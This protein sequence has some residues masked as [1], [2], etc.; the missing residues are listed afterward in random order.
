MKLG[1]CQVENFSSYSS[2]EFDFADLSLSLVYG[3]TGAGKSTLCDIAIW[4]LYGITAKNGSADDVRSWTNTESPTKVVLDVTLANG[5][6]I[7]VVRTRGR[8][9]QNDLYWI[10]ESGGYQ[11][12][13]DMKDTQA[14]LTGVLG[15][16][17]ESYL[18]TAYY[19]DSSPSGAFF[20]ANAKARRELFERI[21]D[22]SFPKR[23][24]EK[25]LE[26]KKS[27]SKE[28][29]ELEKRKS[30]LDGQL[31]SLVDTIARTQI[32]ATDWEKLQTQKIQ[33]LQQL[34]DNFDELKAKKTEAFAASSADWSKDHVKVLNKLTKDIKAL[35]VD[36]K[37]F[38]KLEDELIELELETPGTCLECQQPLDANRAKK[39]ELRQLLST[40]QLKD[41]ICRQL[42]KDLQERS[43]THNPY[44]DQLDAAEKMTNVYAERVA[45]AKQDKNPYDTTSHRERYARLKDD[46]IDLDQFIIK[47]QQ[48]YHSSIQLYTLSIQ[49]RGILIQNTVLE[50]QNKANYYLD[51]YFESEFTLVLAANEDNIDCDIVKNGYI[52]SYRQLSKGQKGILKLVFAI[53][54]MGAASNNAGLHMDNLFFDES[55]DGLDTD[56]KLKAF[57]LFSE[58]ALS[59]S[60]I[61]VIDHATEFKSLF[62]NQFEVTLAGDTSRITS[63]ESKDDQT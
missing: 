60:S 46:S 36:L 11:R 19:S 25:S 4:A 21:A 52:C 37:R 7:T 40:A 50:I 29:E 31:A 8:S 62:Q 49:M 55:L 44:A 43:E 56:L 28:V 5:S 48:L 42:Q 51:K 16:D 9:N 13:K 17:G 10:D 15:Q 27:S 3:A 45:E 32:Q 24:A 54:V 58:L 39:E 35:R 18:S 38:R 23:L 61:I 14:F 30:H 53:S 59:H 57:G 22:L 2:L 63:N 6:T 33:K 20:M 12:G 41:S 34:S 1:K 47:S 26:S